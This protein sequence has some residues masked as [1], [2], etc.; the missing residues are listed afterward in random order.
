MILKWISFPVGG[1]GV[2]DS[3]RTNSNASCVGE[4]EEGR[5]RGEDV[6]E[7]K[8]EQASFFLDMRF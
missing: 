8:R 1:R 5:W 2:S 6:K 7:I 3:S 4:D